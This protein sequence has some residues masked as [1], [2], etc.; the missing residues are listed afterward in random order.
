MFPDNADTIQL[1]L[2][3]ISRAPGTV[4]PIGT[5]YYPGVSFHVF[6]EGY[7]LIVSPLALGGYH[8]SVCG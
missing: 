8:R 2:K 6:R 5:P 3:R 1:E 7:L 4:Q